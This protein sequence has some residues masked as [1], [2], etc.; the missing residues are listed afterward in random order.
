MPVNDPLRQAA[1][2][3]LPGQLIE[4][5]IRAG[6]VEAGRFTMSAENIQPASLDLRLGEK[7]AR[8]RCSFLPGS[9]TVGH[10]L[11]EYA[12]AELDLRGDGAMLEVGHPYL[13][14]LKERLRLP[15]GLFGRANPKSSTGRVDVFTRVITDRSHRFDEVAPGYEG[16][17]YLEVVPLSF[18]ILV[19]EDLTLNQLRLTMGRPWLDDEAIRRAHEAEPL[20]YR[21]G[22]PVPAD[23]LVLSDGLFLSLDLQGDQSGRVGYSARSHAPLLDL[24]RSGELEP[25]PFWEPV[26]REDGDRVVLSPNKFY[27][28]MSNEAVSVPP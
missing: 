25:G 6:Y 21:A 1:N 18:P 16:A 14:E 12:L 19:R 26:F 9:D 3:V 15:G 2:G 13:V 22:E 27:L 28:L 10:K 7:A 4:H 17:L 23:E 5:A 11:K 24:R 8:I 20:L